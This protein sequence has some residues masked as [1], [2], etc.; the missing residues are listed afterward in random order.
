[1]PG[2]P[3]PW[4]GLWPINCRNKRIPECWVGECLARPGGCIVGWA[5]GNKDW[6]INIPTCRCPK[7]TSNVHPSQFSQNPGSHQAFFITDREAFPGKGGTRLGSG[8]Q[9]V[10][11]FLKSSPSFFRAGISGWGIGIQ[12]RIG[13]QNGDHRNKDMIRLGC[14]RPNSPQL[15]PTWVHFPK[16]EQSCLRWKCD[17]PNCEPQPASPVCAR[18]PA[19]PPFLQLERYRGVGSGH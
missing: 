4:P 9:I 2:R 3:S 6:Q 14:Y 16:L 19:G 15:H 10:R 12:S 11:S 8:F 5:P 7:L 1:M 13:L 17:C 18:C